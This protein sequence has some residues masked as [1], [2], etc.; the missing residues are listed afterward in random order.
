MTAEEAV[1]SRLASLSA[2]T[3]LV[4]T[5]VYVGRLPQNPTYPCVLVTLIATTDGH[6]LRGNDG[7]PAVDIQV[8]AFARE[9]NGVS[10]RPMAIAVGQAI[11]GDGAGSGL[12]GFKGEVAGSPPAR[13]AG[14]FRTDGH[15][16]YN[17]EELRVWCC[18][19]DYRVW[20]A[21]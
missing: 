5:R 11:N 14:I 2:V 7:L 12:D 21:G 6:H 17:P 13:I 1:A 18:S 3:A 16:F 20:M 4:G 8:D 10:P 15:D 9:T 19:Q